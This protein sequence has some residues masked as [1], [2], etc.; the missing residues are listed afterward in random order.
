MSVVICSWNRKDYLRSTLQSVQNQTYSDIEIIVVDNRSEDGSIEMV[1]KEFPKVKLIIMPDSFYGACETFNIGFANSTGEFIAILD[2]DV[3]LIPEWIER[4]VAKFH[5]EPNKTALIASK[6]IG[7]AGLTWPSKEKQDSEFLCGDF[8]G[9][10]AM[11]RRDALNRTRYYPKE[12]F[13]F[14]NEEVLAAQLLNLGYRLLY[15]PSAIT[16]HKCVISQR[17][18]RRRFY[19]VNR[20]KLWTYWMYEP[21]SIAIPKS[22]WHLVVNLGYFNYLIQGKVR[23]LYAVTYLKSTLDALK[24]LPTC[25]RNRQVV[26]SLYWRIKS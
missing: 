6:I 16:Y 17:M 5:K 4:I 15:L 22:I 1:R 23:A 19:F 14:W 13:V 11:V 9:A 21:L 8:V 10:G 25:L 7:P 24:G 26:R 18:S 12:Y 20:N 2:D 3:S